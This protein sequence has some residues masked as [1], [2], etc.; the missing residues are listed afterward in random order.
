[1]ATFTDPHNYSEGFDY[2]I[3]NGVPVVAEGQI[4]DARPGQFV[5]HGEEAT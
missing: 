4:T 3:V 5:A 2:V 1:M